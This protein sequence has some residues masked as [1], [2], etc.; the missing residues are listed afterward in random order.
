[1][2]Y[3]LIGFGGLGKVHFKNMKGLVEAH[4]DVKLVAI[5]DVTESI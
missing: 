5:C 1:M 2:N 3:A 4:P